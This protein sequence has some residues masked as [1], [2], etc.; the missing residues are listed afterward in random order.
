MKEQLILVNQP[1][2]VRSRDLTA[3]ANPYTLSVEG[4]PMDKGDI[5]KPAKAEVA[6]QA[7]KSNNPQELQQPV[8]TIQ[9]LRAIAEERRG[10]GASE[11]EIAKETA[12]LLYKLMGDETFQGEFQRQ[13]QEATQRVQNGESL[14]QVRK[15]LEA[16]T[17]SLR[18]ERQ[19]KAQV[20]VEEMEA[21]R[22]GET[23]EAYFKRINI[24]D[25]PEA[26]ARFQRHRA[27]DLENERRNE[28][29][30]REGERLNEAMKSRTID[31]T[32]LESFTP[33]AFSDL[34]LRGIAESVRQAADERVA[35]GSFFERQISRVEGFIDNNEVNTK[36]ANQLLRNLEKFR[37]LSVVKISD[38][39]YEEA[40]KLSKEKLMKAIEKAPAIESGG[41]R[42]E[43]LTAAAKNEEVS[44]MLIN[45][46]LFKS[47][48][49]KTETNQ[50]EI[51]LYASSNLDTLL[52]YLSRSR[53]NNPE[54]YPYYVSL[55]NAAQLFHTMN[56][57]IQGGG[58]EEF[59]RVAEA[60]NFQHFDLMKQIKGV[61]E[62]LRIFDQMFSEAKARD[63]RISTDGYKRIKA[64][65]ERAFLAF[66]EMGGIKSEYTENRISEANEIIN[67]P[68]SSEEEKE[69]ARRQIEEAPKLTKWETQ[70]ALNVARTYFNI[71]F[72]SAEQVASG[73][74]PRKNQDEEYRVGSFPFE[75][76]AKLMNPLEWQNARFGIAGNRGG[77]AFLNMVK[78]EFFKFQST[79]F[80]R[81]DPLELKR[82]DV[83]LKRKE[84]EEIYFG[85]RK[86]G[87]N[88]LIEFGG[89]NT[90]ELE[91]GGLIGSASIYRGWQMETMAFPYITV[92]YK[93]LDKEGKVEKDSKGN[94][95]IVD[96]NLRQWIRDNNP[97]EIA[98][99]VNERNMQERQQEL[100]EKIKPLIHGFDEHNPG[101]AIGL[102]FLLKQGFVAN[103][104][105]Y[106]ARKAIWERVAEVNLPVLIDYMTNIKSKDSSVKGVRV[107]VDN[108]T[109]K[110]WI[111]EEG[112]LDTG[113]NMRRDSNGNLVNEEGNLVKMV[114]G[115]QEVVRDE[116]G[117]PKRAEGE[118]GQTRWEILKDKI[119]LEQQRR[120]KINSAGF[121]DRKRVEKEILEIKF[122]GEGEEEAVKMLKKEGIRMAPHLADIL[123]PYVPF[124]N[125]VP[126]EVLNMA[127][128]GEEFYKR[129]TGGDLPSF[130]K[131]VSAFTSIQDNPGGIG[132]EKLLEQLHAFERGIE[133]PQGPDFAQESTFPVVSAILDFIETKPEDRWIGK[134]VVKR[135]FRQPTSLAEEF[136]GIEADSKTEAEIANLTHHM[137]KMGILSE[138]L[139]KEMRKRKGVDLWGIIWALFRDFGPLF[140]IGIAASFVKSASPK[141]E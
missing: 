121:A 47:Y 5:S 125:D 131:A 115:K 136:S 114:N 98:K 126:F 135:F 32:I 43:L 106:E 116:S 38:E 141:I 84:G 36:E 19:I 51:N 37:V 90:D 110:E 1:Q 80:T 20:G 12:E 3:K 107:R 138:S 72:R 93:K 99:G 94:E 17:P 13:T 139:G 57:R 35:D 64:D 30:R 4:I 112:I 9:A 119:F 41:F 123:F 68:K 89:M 60:I 45:K 69:E 7:Q 132:D 111:E 62:A 103:E 101:L 77:V 6:P 122:D 85:R 67:N 56:A 58:I 96:A 82:D 133:Q 120:V 49:D 140:P 79:K 52:G 29:Y 74:V 31:P 66:N 15:D 75:T 73:Q 108:N 63:K 22:K 102:G 44:D 128:P 105:G 83:T 78:A 14:E 81:K 50:Y 92:K 39:E 124:M 16:Q 48:E 18:R 70:R 8:D 127:G 118:L 21:I 23:D 24:K 109:L 55:R 91:I 117:K 87:I 86:Q 71:T 88:Q 95:V 25:N 42:Q 65:T 54:K 27:E 129:R 46:I 26:Q 113:W 10:A 97:G 100:L 2:I 76:V 61:P 137:V 28:E 134:N 33:A 40:V 11:Q 130:Y 53:T 104:V 34:R 59:I